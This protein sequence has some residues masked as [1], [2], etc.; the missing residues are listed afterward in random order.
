MESEIVAKSEGDVK[1]VYRRLSAER[2]G[3]AAPPAPGP[4]TALE[5][6]VRLQTTLGDSYE[7]QLAAQL[8]P[9]RAHDLRA[10]RKGWESRSSSSYGCP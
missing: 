2:A 8:G 7:K 9:A 5:R 3:L 10:K 4:T 1:D 6:M